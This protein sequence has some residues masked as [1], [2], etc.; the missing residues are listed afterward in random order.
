MTHWRCAMSHDTSITRPLLGRNTFVYIC[1]TNVPVVR[2][3]NPSRADAVE[4]ALA[5]EP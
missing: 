4:N 5:Y 2:V 3:R 1:N